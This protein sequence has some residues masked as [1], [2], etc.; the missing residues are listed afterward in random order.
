V[1]R[2]FLN[3]GEALLR[4]YP[5]IEIEV[6]FNYDCGGAGLIERYSRARKLSDRLKVIR[7]FD[8]SRYDLIYVVDTPQLLANHPSIENKL[9]MEC[10]T[11]YAEN[12][13]YL[14]EWQTRVKTLIVPSSG[15]LRVIEDEWPGL[16]G[17]V[18][19]VRNFVPHLPPMDRPLSLPSWRGPL[20]LYFSRIDELK[21]FAE[22]VEGLSSARRYLQKEPLGIVSGQILP[23][24]PLTEVMEKHHVRGSIAILP[25][26][27]FESSHVLMHM[28]RQKRAVF[29]SPSKGESFGLSA[30]EAMTAGLPVIL[31]DIPPHAALVSNRAKFL[32]PLGDIQALARKMA[33]AT[34]QYDESSAECVELSREFSEEAFLADWEGIFANGAGAV[35]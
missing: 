3:R 16:R 6:F 11:P 9:V 2:V 26:V 24:Y 25:P 14:K 13:T 35:V 4:R 10:H 22:F 5:K 19:V 32:Y 34:E 18:K 23:G 8:S 29:V 33:A 1:E 15:F 7:T 17:K 30:A 12:R 27:P 28:L 20:F 31:S 21:N